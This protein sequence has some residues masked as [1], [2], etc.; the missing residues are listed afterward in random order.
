MRDLETSNFP[1]VRAQEGDWTTEE[2]LTLGHAV[3]RPADSPELLLFALSESTYQEWKPAAALGLLLSKEHP[4]SSLV[5]PS[6]LASRHLW[7][8]S[9]LLSFGSLF[10]C[11]PNPHPRRPSLGITPVPGSV[12]ETPHVSLVNHWFTRPPMS[13]PPF[14]NCALHPSICLRCSSTLQT[15]G[16][17]ID[18][19][20]TLGT[21]VMLCSGL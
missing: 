19:K 17:S 11:A 8:E 3:M 13:L 20:K 9:K 7:R 10:P 15:F 18:Q 6:F 4:F 21:H 2:P 12:Q 1:L 14:S 5:R 16:P